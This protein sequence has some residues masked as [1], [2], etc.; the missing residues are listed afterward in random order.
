MGYQICK[1]RFEPWI[2]HGDLLV[3]I[4]WLIYVN[5]LFYILGNLDLPYHFLG[6]LFDHLLHNFI[7][8]FP[9]H[10]YVLR[11]LNDLID[12]PL[13]PRNVLWNLYLDLHD[14]L[15]RHLFYDLNGLLNNLVNINR[16]L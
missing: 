13:W 7:G 15:H 1:L 2:C 3:N 5:R 16:R 11:H 8:H 14:L 12:Y 6:N 10:L 4:D 9:L